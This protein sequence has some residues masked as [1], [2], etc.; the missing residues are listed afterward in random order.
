MRILGPGIKTMLPWAIG[1]HKVPPSA[2]GSPRNITNQSFKK[3]KT[4]E[5][6][7][8]EWTL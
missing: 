3:K 1:R 5:N 6:R 4:S 7:Y 8:I 2:T